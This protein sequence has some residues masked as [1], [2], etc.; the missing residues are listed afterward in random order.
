MIRSG[1]ILVVDDE[2]QNLVLLQALLARLGHRAVGASGG[3][4]ALDAL[5]PT[6]DLA[7]VDLMMPGM[8]GFE[9]V[10]RIRATPET[11]DLP[12]IM[13]TSLTDKDDRLKAVEAGAN[14]YVTKPVDLLELRVRTASM[15]RQKAHQDEI[16]AFQADL[17]RMVESRTLEL[18]RALA[19]LNEAHV[20]TIHHL[21]A[22]AEYKDEDTAEHIGRMAYYSW[23]IARRMGLGRDEAD[24]IRTCS[25]MHDVGKIGI[26]DSV[27][28]KPG[29]L[30]PQEWA[31]MKQH[32]IIGGNILA[33]GASDYMVLGRIIALTHHERWDGKGY[34]AGLAG[35]AIPLTGRI[36]AVA[37]VFDALTSRRPYKEPLPADQAREMMRRERG[38]HFDP[39]VLDVFL[40]GL[41]GMLAERP[42]EFL[43]ENAAR[44]LAPAPWPALAL[45]PAPGTDSGPAPADPATPPPGDS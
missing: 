3:A 32:P 8:D 4:Q 38:T 12:V 45:S 11:R 20:E 33:S 28:L 17:A 15:L 13:V 21:S 19:E 43:P 27:L 24:L 10:R 30:T 23:A 35:D 42:R 41:D 26:P 18:R 9:L 34:P 5:D 31:I 37:D 14:D 6:F 7:L 25:P 1:K 16:K 29:A 2:E 44:S 40:D 39:K 22:A 36:C